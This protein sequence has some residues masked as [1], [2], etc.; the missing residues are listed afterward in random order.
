MEDGRGRGSPSKS[1]DRKTCMG[2]SASTQRQGKPQLTSPKAFDPFGVVVSQSV[3]GDKPLLGHCSQ[4]TTSA[5]LADDHIS[6][7]T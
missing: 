3:R 7:T 4:N 5:L 1:L 6:Q 2:G